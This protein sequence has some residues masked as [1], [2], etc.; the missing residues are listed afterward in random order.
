MTEMTKKLEISHDELELIA[1]ALETQTKILRMQASAGGHGA[2]KRLDEV[3][4]VLATVTRQTKKT[5]ST[6]VQQSGF[7]GLLRSMGEAT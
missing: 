5:H 4:R 2:K 6:S 1:S 3:R 7:W